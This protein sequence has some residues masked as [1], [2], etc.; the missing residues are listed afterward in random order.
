M[1]LL[2]AEK[3]PNRIERILTWRWIA[4]PPS[5]EDEDTIDTDDS[6][7]TGEKCQGWVL[8]NGNMLLG[9][10]ARRK[11]GVPNTCVLCME[12][13]PMHVHFHE[14]MHNF[15][16]KLL[17]ATLIYIYIYI[18]IHTTLCLQTIQLL[19]QCLSAQLLLEGKDWFP[20]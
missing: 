14:Q 10:Q 11:F 6:V 3:L 20:G 9:K 7:I 13:Q 18:C 12:C 4:L 1:F 5:D 8:L 19:Q 16:Y 17:V 15:Y 2:Q